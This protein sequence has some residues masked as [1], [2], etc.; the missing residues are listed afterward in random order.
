MMEKR[1]IIVCKGL[2]RSGNHA[3]LD[4]V[5]SL[6]PAHAFY[7]N[8]AHMLFADKDALRAL[9]DRHD[10]PCL[11]FSFEDSI[12]HA[13]DPS[14]PLLDSVVSFPAD[15]FPEFEV[16]DLMILRDPYNNWASR[17]AANDRVKTGGK[18]LTSD[19]SWDLFRTNWLQ[20]AGRHREQPQAVML[21]NFWKNNESYRREI[22]AMLGGTYS[23]A[24][25]ETVPSNASGSSFDGV[26]R[27]TRAEILK[28]LPA[29]FSAEFLARLTSRPGYYVRRFVNPPQTGK[30][31]KVDERW[32]FLLGR[33]EGQVL[34]SDDRIRTEAL[35]IFGKAFDVNGQPLEASKAA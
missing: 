9:I 3:I 4:W 10:E 7:N 8:Q 19:P 29:Y 27:P 14:L 20:I 24:T 16:F 28:K 32:K 34:F 25:L 15:A 13:D 21:F 18:G 11:I 22:C 2:Q 31:M 17:V 33:S 30:R 6:W 35:R 23:E 12:K 5:A 1:K 26:P